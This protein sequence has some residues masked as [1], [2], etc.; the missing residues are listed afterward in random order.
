MAGF[1][2]DAAA[3]AAHP[4]NPH[5]CT[6]TSSGTVAVW[7]MADKGVVARCQMP[8]AVT[9]LAYSPDGA[10]LAVGLDTGA[11]HLLRGADEVAGAQLEP[12]HAFRHCKGAVTCLAAH[13]KFDPSGATAEG[14]GGASAIVSNA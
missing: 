13:P 14:A 3:V 12:L 8:G 2:A 7:S 1:D 4:V 5:F 10:V 11:V 6:G 9:R